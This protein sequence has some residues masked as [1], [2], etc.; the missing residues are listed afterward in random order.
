MFKWRGKPLFVRHRSQ[1]EI[2]EVNSVDIATL[3]DPQQD[4]DR[5]IKP[6]WLILVGK[7]C[8]SMLVVRGVFLQ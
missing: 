8:M 7:S 5:V 1:E 6:E 4:S 2:D 3:R